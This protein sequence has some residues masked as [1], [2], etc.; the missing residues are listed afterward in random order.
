MFSKTRLCATH[1]APRPSGSLRSRS[2]YVLYFESLI[3]A[4]TVIYQASGY[5][6]GASAPSVD[7]ES[8]SH[9]FCLVCL[10]RFSSKSGKALEIKPSR[11]PNNVI[12]VLSSVIYLEMCSR[13][14]QFDSDTQNESQENA[15]SCDFDDRL[16]CSSPGISPGFQ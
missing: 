5:D 14:L 12:I 16:P 6:R 1:P 9:V 15:C 10:A 7:R 11:L 2:P 4:L 3:S 8:A 13:L